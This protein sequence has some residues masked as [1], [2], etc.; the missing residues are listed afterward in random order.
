MWSTEAEGAVHRPPTDIIW[1]SCSMW[2]SGN[3][4]VTSLCTKAGE[5]LKMLS[6]LHSSLSL[7]QTV[8]TFTQRKEASSSSFTMEETDAAVRSF[9]SLPESPLP[10]HVQRRDP[11]PHVGDE[12][13]FHQQVSIVCN[14]VFTFDLFSHRVTPKGAIPVNVSSPRRSHEFLSC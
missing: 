4:T 3:K 14:G 10:R 5:V 1:K 6:P 8:A 2:G 12:H 13:V 11:L 7:S 9:P